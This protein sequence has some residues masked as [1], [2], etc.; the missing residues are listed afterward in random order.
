MCGLFFPYE[1]QGAFTFGSGPDKK[2]VG[3]HAFAQGDL[4]CRCKDFSLLETE[5]E[6]CFNLTGLK[7]GF[8][9]LLYISTR[10]S[11]FKCCALSLNLQK[12]GITRQHVLCAV[13]VNANK[14]PFA[15]S[16]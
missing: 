9:I 4:N 13:Q 7:F 11:V 8:F 6:F 15:F 5:I 2:A 3:W 16:R 12:F 10:F 1:K 14:K